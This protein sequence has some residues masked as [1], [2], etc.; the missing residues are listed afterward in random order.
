MVGPG[1]ELSLHAAFDL[2]RFDPATFVRLLGHVGTLLGAI[3]D[4]PESR[5]DELPLAE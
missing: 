2:A 1:Q 3:S 4:A 5:L